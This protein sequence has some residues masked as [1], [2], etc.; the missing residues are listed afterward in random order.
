[1]NVRLTRRMTRGRTRFL[2]GLA[3]A[4]VA[5]ALLTAAQAATNVVVNPGFEQG[6][7]GATTPIVCGWGS[8]HS[9][10]QD[11]T[12]LH[13]GS[14]SLHLDCGLDISCTASTDPAFCAA[15]GAGVHPASFWYG[16][17][18][19]TQVSL[20]ATFF[21]TSDCTGPGSFASLDHISAGSGWQQVTGALAAPAGTQ[22]ALYAVG[23]SDECVFAC[24]AGGGCVCVAAANFDDI[25]VEDPGDTNPPTISSFT[26]TSGPA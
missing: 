15:I 11:T 22:S 8:D 19:G 21:P 9:I 6:G 5:L 18:V 12:N 1:M 10:A 13:S 17:L 3:G 24:Q 2:L 26:P 4:A 20:S 25:D 14:A 7:C 23:A 16:N